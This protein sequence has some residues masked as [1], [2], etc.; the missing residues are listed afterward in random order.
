MGRVTKLDDSID[1]RTEIAN[2][3][4]A[5]IRGN[6]T[7]TQQALI[8]V[9]NKM[10]TALGELESLSGNIRQEMIGIRGHLL[11]SLEKKVRGRKDL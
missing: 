6:A 5:V 8:Y 11:M 9:V 7:D 1:V 4:A 2:A 10:G 3:R